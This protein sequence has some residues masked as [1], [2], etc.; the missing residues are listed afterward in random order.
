[1]FFFLKIDVLVFERNGEID[2][3]KIKLI[4]FAVSYQIENREVRI[5]SMYWDLWGK[6]LTFKH[7]I[8]YKVSHD[9]FVSS[10]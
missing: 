4:A 6:K 9:F 5:K 7:Q 8:P 10:E 2:Q 3:K 1:M